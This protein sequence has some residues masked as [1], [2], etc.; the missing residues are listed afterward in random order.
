MVIRRIREH[1]TA[2]N[3]FAVG[4]DFLIVVAGIVIG[5]QVNNWN[6]ARIEGEQSRSYRARLIDELDFNARQYRQQISYYRQVRR[7]GLTALAG[8]RNV[9]NL[10]PR[11]F[12]VA[13]Y[14]T[15][16]IDTSPPKTYIYDELVSAGLV[17][18]LGDESIQEAAS[19]YYLQA[20]ANI[21]S[22][23]EVFPYRTIIRGVMPYP[24]QNEIRRRCGDIFVYFEQR[25]IGVRLP[26]RCDIVLESAESA[27]GVA[28]VR[29]VPGIMRELTR[30]LA[31]TDERLTLLND[32]L[33]LANELRGKLIEAVRRD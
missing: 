22:F 31:S 26:E 18:R 2:H 6:Q 28:Q 11:D 30:Y 15:S 19:D 3:W 13:A 9:A 23:Q 24:L 16:Q 1:V 4:I 7:H 8:F 27:Q 17:D 32:N 29:R 25:I 12:L 14:Q 21:R 10:A 20:A 33:Q 5:T